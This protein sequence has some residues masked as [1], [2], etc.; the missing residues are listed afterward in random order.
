MKG[1]WRFLVEGGRGEKLPS[2]RKGGALTK[3]KRRQKERDV[4]LPLSSLRSEYKV[5]SS[6]K[7][8]GGN[9]LT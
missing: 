5:D 4:F 3:K 6:Q 1:G 7:R 8:G 9:I 2:F